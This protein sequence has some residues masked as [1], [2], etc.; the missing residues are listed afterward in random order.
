MARYQE[1]RQRFGDEDAV[2][3]VVRAPDLFTREVLGF[4]DALGRAVAALPV[5]A[6]VTSLTTIEDIAGTAGGVEVRPLVPDLGVGVGDGA[7]RALRARTLADP[8]FPGTIVSRDGRTTAILCE[9]RASSTASNQTAVAGIERVLADV[10][11]PPEIEVHVAGWPSANFLMDRL[12]K[13]DLARIPACVRHAR[14]LRGGLLP[15]PPTG[16]GHRPGR[17]RDDP[18]DHGRVRR[19]LVG[20]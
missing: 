3:V 20:R 18:L 2:F 19:A 11:R 16:R 9:L 15:R 12:T 5:V 17:G 7:L 10:H 14:S 4:I 13:R 6:R 8:F 1:F